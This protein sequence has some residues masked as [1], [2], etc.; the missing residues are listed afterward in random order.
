MTYGSDA[1]YLDHAATTPTDPAVVQVM[2]PYFTQQFGNPSSI[3]R[4][5]QDARAALDRARAQVARVLGAKTSEIVFTSGAT[6][7]N[8]LA[9]RGVAW[10]ARLKASHGPAPHI[11]TSVV[12]HHAVLHTCD[13][14]E[15]QGFVVTRVACD[16]E[17]RVRPEDIEAAIRPETCLISVMYA[18]NEVG[19]IQPVA[20]IGAIARRHGI[21]FHTDAVQAAGVRSLNVNELGIDLLSLSAHKF[22][23]PKGVGLV[24]LRKHTPIEF[25]QEGGGQESGR[26]GGTENVPLIVGMAEAL[27][28]ADAGRAAYNAFCAALRDRLWEGIRTSIDDVVL[29]GPPL[30]A[31]RLPNNL[32]VS[33]RGVQGETVLLSLDMGGVAASA[34][35]ACTT[36]NAEPSHVLLASGLSEAEARASLRLTVGRGNSE[37]EIDGAIDTLRETVDRVRTLSKLSAD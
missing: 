26:R 33:F 15:R 6:E 11:V 36:G 34:G 35:S 7:S 18:N 25:Q 22:Y 31:T 14:L 28:R 9:I 32:N 8:N 23:G 4:T 20:E 10:A 37:A 5:G 30:D 24:Y 19:T 29:N 16:N 27:A 1:I 2:L 3:Y 17:G 21:P 13:A 12:E